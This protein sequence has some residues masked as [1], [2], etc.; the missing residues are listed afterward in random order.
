MFFIERTQEPLYKTRVLVRMG[1]MAPVP[2]LSGDAPKWR[3]SDSM[4]HL[5][6]GYFYV[7]V[8]YVKMK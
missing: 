2:I 8:T 4:R 6:H 5:L 3:K 1:K 7:F